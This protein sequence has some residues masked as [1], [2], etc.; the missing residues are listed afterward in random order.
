MTAAELPPLADHN[1]DLTCAWAIGLTSP[2][3]GFGD[4][5]R[6]II[7]EVRMLRRVRVTL[8]QLMDERRDICEAAISQRD[9]LRAEREALAEVARLLTVERD[10]L[11]A[12]SQRLR[13][14]CN[15]PRIAEQMMAMERDLRERICLVEQERDALAKQLARQ[16]ESDELVASLRAAAPNHEECWRNGTALLARA[17]KAEAALAGKV[18]EAFVEKWTSE[19]AGRDWPGRVHAET[20]VRSLLA[21][22]SARPVSPPKAERRESLAEQRNRLGMTPLSVEQ[23]EQNVATA[24]DAVCAGSATLPPPKAEGLTVA[25]A[26][27]DP[28]VRD[29]SMWVEATGKLFASF[30]ADW[31]KQWRFIARPQRGS[32]AVYFEDRIAFDDAPLPDKWEPGSLEPS[33]ID[34]PCTLVP[35]ER[36]PARRALC[37][38]RCAGRATTAPAS[39]ARSTGAPSPP[40]SPP[41]SHPS[42]RSTACWWRSG[43][44]SGPPSPTVALTLKSGRLRSSAPS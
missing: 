10:E 11:R 15:A 31:R 6:R 38:R 20:V 36:V 17:E 16:V 22:L 1:L 29:G 13:T 25:D 18:D 7:A 3:V 12:E 28:R 32:V 33:D 37:A 5:V 30:D 21:D 26:L 24:V 44:A 19:V 9:T 4:N 2:N 27:R 35:A 34:H 42:P 41:R 8:G 40:T 43:T 39:A 14:T 23:R